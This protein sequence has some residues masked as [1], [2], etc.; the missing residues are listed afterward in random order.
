MAVEVGQVGTELCEAL[1]LDANEVARIS[2][3]WQPT[4]TAIINV[5]IHVLTTGAIG[6]IFK[7]YELVEA[8]S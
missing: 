4:Q 2:F 7:R 3:D 8:D 6:K 5:E 1:G